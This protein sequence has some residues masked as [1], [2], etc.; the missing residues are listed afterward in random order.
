MAGDNDCSILRETVR[1]EGLSQT[2]GQFVQYCVRYEGDLFAKT[3]VRH[4]SHVSV[5][6][7]FCVF[8]EL[9]GEISL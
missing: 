6:H 7:E 2:Q 5:L 3:V 8:V 1:A 9:F 4:K